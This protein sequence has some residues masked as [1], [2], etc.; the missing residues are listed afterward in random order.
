MALRNDLPSDEKQRNL[1]EIMVRWDKVTEEINKKVNLL[2]TSSQFEI[3]IRKQI[4][5]IDNSLALP[6]K[7][8]AIVFCE[9]VNAVDPETGVRTTGETFDLRI[10]G[11][12]FS[13]A[14]VNFNWPDAYRDTMIIIDVKRMTKK[15]EYTLAHEIVHGAGNTT[16]DNQGTPKN[17]MIYKDAENKS[18]TDVNLEATDKAKL[19]AADFII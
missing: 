13:W 19:E 18:P 7:R 10:K 1:E 16:A 4:F 6:K 5:P 9:F 17:I 15:Y 8:L 14:T 3:D 12:F 11:S 2:G